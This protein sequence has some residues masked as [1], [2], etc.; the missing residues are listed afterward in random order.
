MDRVVYGGQF[1]DE[2][3][4]KIVD[5]FAAQMENLE[6][7]VRYQGGTNAGHTFLGKDGRAIK[8]HGIPS[9][10]LTPGIM[11]YLLS[12]V[13]INPVKL[14]EEIKNL[15]NEHGIE[16][17]PDNF[18]ISG[19]VNITLPYHIDRNALDEHRKGKRVSTRRGIAQTAA[20]K[21]NYD[22][23]RMADF[24]DDY[25]TEILKDELKRNMYLL[26]RDLPED[27]NLSVPL[28][29]NA[30]L[31]LLN[32]SR[33]FLKDF[34]VDEFD[35]RKNKKGDWLCEGAQGFL[36][37]IDHGPQGNTASNPHETPYP[38]DER[39][40]VMKAIPSRVGDAPRIGLLPEEIAKIVSGKKGEIDAEFGATTGFRRDVCYFDGVAGKYAATMTDPDFV[41][42]TKLDKMRGVPLKII[43][44]YNTG[45]GI[46]HH[47][48]QERALY[49]ECS[50][51]EPEL[52]DLPICHEDICGETD[53]KKLSGEYHEVVKII[54]DVCGFNIRY[55][56]TGVSRND[57]IER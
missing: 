24:V 19:R 2:G 12:K 18:G 23:I 55:L 13:Y 33:K 1:G 17:T 16:I 26:N 25:F 47:V 32:P 46:I 4:G 42:L 8:S 53:W 51:H 10:I 21:Y 56:S 49:E 44:G 30:Y 50:K 3:K 9:G 48:P 38:V 36:L 54:E 27:F 11:N 5:Y 34:I 29:A 7:V 57:I 15:H 37:G 40:M 22:G 28:D 41:V 35:L 45:N 43:T 14:V 31:K 52:M 6:A 20:D 39:I